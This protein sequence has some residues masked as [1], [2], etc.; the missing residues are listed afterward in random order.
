MN[1]VVVVCCFELTSLLCCRLFHGMVECFCN[2]SDLLTSCGPIHMHH[3]MHMVASAHA[4]GCEVPCIWSYDMEAMAARLYC[5]LKF[6]VNSYQNTLQCPSTVRDA[7]V[8][9]QARQLMG[10]LIHDIRG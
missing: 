6:F 10:R 1:G 8:S 9:S 2:V 5:V 4:N 7:C 3:P